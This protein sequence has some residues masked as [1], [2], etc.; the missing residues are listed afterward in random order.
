MALTKANKKDIKFS[1]L[2]KVEMKCS[3]SDNTRNDEESQSIFI[4]KSATNTL[5]KDT[6]FYFYALRNNVFFQGNKAD[7]VAS[8]I[9]SATAN[10]VEVKDLVEPIEIILNRYDVDKDVICKYWKIGKL[11]S[12]HL[13][14]CDKS[15]II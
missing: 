3:V 13:N 1:V 12:N 7:K 10:G 8:I 2:S 15:L 14:L 11:I 5:P 6:K 9:I 4:P